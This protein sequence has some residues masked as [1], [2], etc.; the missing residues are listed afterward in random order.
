[1]TNLFYFRNL[2]SVG[3]TE[4]FFYYLAKKYSKCDIAIVYQTGDLEQI[5]RI[6]KYARC[7]KYYGQKFKCKKAFFNYNMEIID[8]VEAEEYYAL[9]HGDYNDYKITPIQ[10]EKIKHYIGVSDIAVKSFKSILPGKDI[11]RIYNPVAVDQPQKTLFLISATRLTQEKGK[12]LIIRMADKLTQSGRPWIWLIFTND[13]KAINNSHILYLPPTLNVIDYINKCDYLVQLS[14]AEGYGYSPVEALSIGKPV[15]VTDIPAMHE[16]GVKDGENGFILKKDLSNLDIDKLYEKTW[17]FSYNPPK[18]EWDKI[19]AKG[20]RKEEK[21]MYKIK[22]NKRYLDVQLG[23]FVE[24][25]EEYVV[26]DLRAEEIVGKGFAKIIEE[27]KYKSKL[28][29][30]PKNK[31]KGAT[32]NGN[33]Q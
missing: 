10:H 6:S 27:V 32:T 8:N 23:R 28:I 14:R 20:K 11:Q 17:E 15:I 12:D 30:Q 13:R 5:K 33:H 18:D 3:G 22:A 25:D 9:I 7:I 1:M 29:T 24:K 4:T 19:L 16:I 21:Y 26:E 31:K 2:N